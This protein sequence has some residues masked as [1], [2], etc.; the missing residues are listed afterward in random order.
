MRTQPRTGRDVD[1]QGKMSP[2]GGGGVAVSGYPCLMKLVSAE[3]F[4]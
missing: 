1:G 3:K 4:G 2:G